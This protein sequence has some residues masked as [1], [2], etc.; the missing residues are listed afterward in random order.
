MSQNELALELYRLGFFKAELRPQA[1]TA[2]EMMD[3]EGRD[4][5]IM[6]LTENSDL[7]IINRI[8]PDNLPISKLNSKSADFSEIN[9]DTDGDSHQKTKLN[10]EGAERS[11]I[12]DMLIKAEDLA[13]PKG[14]TL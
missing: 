4:E 3:F 6:K 9:N 13:Y 10:P 5:L 7:E 2:L 1:L 12:N 8:S 14:A 11:E